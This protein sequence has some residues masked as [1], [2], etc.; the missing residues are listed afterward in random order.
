MDKNINSFG[1]NIRLTTE[2]GSHDEFI[3]AKISGFPVGAAGI[4]P[5]FFPLGA[6]G[7]GRYG[8]DGRRASDRFFHGQSLRQRY[9]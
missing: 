2:G 8:A 7:V 4:K 5:G 1:K 6:V 9:L 3:T